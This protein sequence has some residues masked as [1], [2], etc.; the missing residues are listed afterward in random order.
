VY[1]FSNTIEKVRGDWMNR[2]NDLKRKLRRLKK[3]ELRLR[4]QGVPP[5]PDRLVWSRF[6]TGQPGKDQGKYSF[7]AMA[8]DD[9]L[10]RQAFDDFITTLY[11]QYYNERGMLDNVASTMHLAELGLPPDASPEA[12]KAQFRILFK[13]HHPDLG[14]DHHKMIELLNL[15]HK[16][17]GKN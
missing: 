8:E 3:L 4:F 14:G 10:R 6:F 9:S 5:D 16:L 2:I 12:I 17:A 11:Y 15:Y 13:K 1:G 7:E